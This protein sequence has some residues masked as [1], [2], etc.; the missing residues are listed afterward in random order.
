MHR[1]N[2]VI[3]RKAGNPKNQT[4]TYTKHKTWPKSNRT[5]G[6]AGLFGRIF[7]AD[8]GVY[9][10]ELSPRPHDTGMVTLAGTQISTNSNCIYALF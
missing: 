1:K 2:V 5:L 3:I 9:F 10:S 8:D 4:K 7:L 6:G